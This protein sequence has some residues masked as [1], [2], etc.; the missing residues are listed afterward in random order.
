MSD[1]HHPVG[2]EDCGDRWGWVGGRGD[3][4]GSVLHREGTRNTGLGIDS[5]NLQGVEAH[6]P[7]KKM[8]T[9]TKI[10]PHTRQGEWLRSLGRGGDME[11]IRGPDIGGAWIRG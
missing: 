1:Y 5:Y 7:K 10:T 6:K 8:I 2:T 3:G 4:G 11:E 9:R